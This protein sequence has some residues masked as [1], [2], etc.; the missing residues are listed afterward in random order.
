MQKMSSQLWE[1]DNMTQENDPIPHFCGSM[2]SVL[3]WSEQTKSHMG[4]GNSCLHKVFGFLLPFILEAD[5]VWLM[6]AHHA[7]LY[8]FID[9]VA[10]ADD[11]LPAAKKLFDLPQVLLLPLQSL[12][13]PWLNG[14][15]AKLQGKIIVS[16]LTQ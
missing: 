4:R 3:L 15:L 6:A 16:P 12:V 1:G 13:C 2:W 10:N 7:I 11:S 8:C 5:A 9:C 14:A